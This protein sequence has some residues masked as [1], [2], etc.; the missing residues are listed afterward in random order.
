MAR[1]ASALLVELHGGPLQEREAARDGS[2][3]RVPRHE[4]QC[5]MWGACHL[6]RRPQRAHRGPASSRGGAR[7]RARSAVPGP[8]R[9]IGAALKQQPYRFGRMGFGHRREHQRCPRLRVLRVHVRAALEGRG[10]ARQVSR[11][12]GREDGEE[13]AANRRRFLDAAIAS[14]ASREL[15]AARWWPRP[16]CRYRARPPRAAPHE[17]TL[18]RAAAALSAAVVGSA[19]RSSSSLTVGMRSRPAPPQASAAAG[20]NP[21]RRSRRRRHP[22]AASPCRHRRSPT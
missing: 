14:S 19:P 17:S 3:R 9:R 18:P 8:D 22:P 1:H 10:G 15:P 2:A 6:A 13:T 5:G 21:R 20:R 7:N 4:R 11:T 12:A 16:G